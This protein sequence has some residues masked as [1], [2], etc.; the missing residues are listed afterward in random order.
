MGFN[1]ARMPREATG[2]SK[3][4][5]GPE[6]AWREVRAV[7]G[8][9]VASGDRLGCR[10]GR[11]ATRRAFT[12]HGT[13]EAVRAKPSFWV[14]DLRTPRPRTLRVPPR[15]GPSTARPRKSRPR[16]EGPTLAQA[17]G[18]RR[19]LTTQQAASANCPRQPAPSR[20][21]SPWSRARQVVESGRRTCL[22]GRRRSRG[23]RWSGRVRLGADGREPAW[24]GVDATLAVSGWIAPRAVVSPSPTWSRVGRPRPQGRRPASSNPSRV[25]SAV[26]MVSGRR[27]LARRGPSPTAARR[28]APASSRSLRPGVRRAV[29]AS[30]GSGRGRSR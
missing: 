23:G 19:R 29:A 28:S 1:D 2:R 4:H 21:A 12:D 20:P 27:S 15:A 7:A 18:N 6:L 17:D 25:P 24:T 11:R 16:R 3:R 26:V 13:V 5:R 30:P 22:R 8:G 9:G 14:V 10:I